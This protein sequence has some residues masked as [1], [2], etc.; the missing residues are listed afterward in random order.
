M[1]SRVA[2]ARVDVSEER[3][4]LFVKV[5]R[6]SELR[7]SGVT[8]NRSTAIFRWD[9]T[10]YVGD[11]RNGN[12]YFMLIL[13]LARWFFPPWRWRR[14]PKRLFLQKPY[15]VTPQKT[16]FF[17]VTVV[18]SSNLTEVN[19]PWRMV[20]SGLLRHVA[21]VGTFAAL[22]TWNSL[23]WDT[24]TNSCCYCQGSPPHCVL[25][26]PFTH[27]LSLCFSSLFFLSFS[28][29]LFKKT[30]LRNIPKS[31][32]SVASLV[33]NKWLIMMVWHQESLSL[34]TSYNAQTYK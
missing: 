13:F 28:K 30:N 11:H 22:N 34:W 12:F 7:T 24:C 21:L 19:L 29:S 33:D 20:S 27:P 23:Q 9:L 5:E 18:K 3:S 25:Q 16:T 2:L 31:S 4:A 14:Y 26:S 6:I 8:S 15:G 32:V 17:I 10:C 1:W